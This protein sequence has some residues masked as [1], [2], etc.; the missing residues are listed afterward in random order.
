MR[1]KK[2]DPFEQERSMTTIIVLGVASL[3]VIISVIG[4]VWGG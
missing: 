1:P 3:L 2:P 4:C